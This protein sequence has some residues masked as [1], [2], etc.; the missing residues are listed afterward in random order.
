MHMTF[1]SANWV[2]VAGDITVTGTRLHLAVLAVTH[3]EHMYVI[4]FGTAPSS[5]AAADARY[6]QV[7][8]RSFQFLS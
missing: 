3:G 1:A 5:F 7:V 2:R 6:F 8:T 4:E